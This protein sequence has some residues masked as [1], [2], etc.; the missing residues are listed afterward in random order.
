V[1]AGPLAAAGVQGLGQRTDDIPARGRQLA[2]MGIGGGAVDRGQQVARGF[3][4]IGQQAVLGGIDA[5]DGFGVE[6]HMDQAR[7][8]RQVI[9]AIRQVRAQVQDKV[10]GPG[11]ERGGA[12]VA[13]E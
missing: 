12:D 1:G 3:A 4:H 10:N 13:K 2:D 9:L 7:A 5:S 8:R 6:A 11:P